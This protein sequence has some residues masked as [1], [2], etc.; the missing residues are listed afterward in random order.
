MTSGDA[1][2]CGVHVGSYEGPMTVRLT[3][4][5]FYCGRILEASGVAPE[6]APQVGKSLVWAEARGVASHGVR[7]LPIY[8]KRFRAGLVR[9]PSAA[10]II[11][12]HTSWSVLDGANGFGAVVGNMAVKDA[13]GRA[14]KEGIGAVWVRNSTHFGA[15]G[16]YAWQMAC[17]GLIGCALSNAVPTMAIWGA[18]EPATGTN[19]IALAAPVGEDS[20]LLLDIATSVASKQMIN[21]SR[22]RGLPIPTGW[23][24]DANGR[25]TDRPERAAVLL[26]FGGH[27]GSGL[28]IFV[29]ILCA[30]LSGAASRHEV[31]RLFSDFDRPEGVGH[32]FMAIDPAR[33]A[34][35]E[36]YHARIRQMVASLRALRPVEGVERVLLPGDRESAA[37]A[38]YVREGISLD[39]GVA[40]ELFDLGD[41]LRL[42][43]PEMM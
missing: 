8:L 24:L 43:R 30:L 11:R 42:P 25:P 6:E 10:Q 2:R 34:G 41:S 31:G 13:V 27:K 15:A 36:A 22:D 3:D 16:Y 18:M 1:P 9:S 39:L 38:L 19:P 7:L 29:E 37:E 26:P 12:Q 35:A 28:A 40:R 23:A 21:L 20:P 32:F 17:Q 33:I 4:L 14:S 5:D